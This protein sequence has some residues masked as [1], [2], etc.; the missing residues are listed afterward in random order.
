VF[1]DGTDL[2]G[3]TEVFCHNETGVLQI[4]ESLHTSFHKYLSRIPDYNR[5]VGEISPY[6][7]S[8]SDYAVIANNSVRHNSTIYTD[9]NVTANFNPSEKVGIGKFI[10]EAPYCPI[11]RQE[12]SAVGNGHMVAQF[13]KVGFGAKS[14]CEEKTILP[15]LHPLPSEVSDPAFIG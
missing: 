8:C 12:F 11:V 13:D 10:P 9:Y 14:H 6:Y 1:F 15:N 2:I 3:R 4:K 5:V 7:A